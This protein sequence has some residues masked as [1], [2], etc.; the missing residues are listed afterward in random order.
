VLGSRAT[1]LRSRIGGMNGRALAAGDR[2]PLAPSSARR[3]ANPRP[4]QYGASDA[5]DLSDSAD[6]QTRVRVLA[7]PQHDRFVADA[8]DVLQSQPYTVTSES[9]RMGFRLEGPRLHHAQTADIISDATPLGSLQVPGDGQP[10][11]LMAERQ[12]TGGYAKVATVISADI[13]I[14]GQ[15]APGDRVSFEVCSMRSAIAAVIARERA[16]MMVST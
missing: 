9:D 6:G 11:L 8:L 16:L 1:H 14:A 15:L 3:R 7:G 4:R 2:L 5:R 10:V 13:G 12:T